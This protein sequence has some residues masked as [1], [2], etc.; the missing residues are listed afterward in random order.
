LP[1]TIIEQTAEKYFEIYSL[2]T[3]KNEL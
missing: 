1:Q 3:G 2:L